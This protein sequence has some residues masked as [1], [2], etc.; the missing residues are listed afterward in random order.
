MEIM[1]QLEPRQKQ[2]WK[3]GLDDHWI[4]TGC[5]D[6]WDAVFIAF[7]EYRD[8]PPSL[9][10]EMIRN[11]TSIDP[12][13]MEKWVLDFHEKFQ[14]KYLERAD[15]DKEQRVF[16]NLLPLRLVST[17]IVPYIQKYIANNNK[18]TKGQLQE[19]IIDK[20]IILADYR[21]KKKGLDKTPDE[22]VHLVYD[23]ITNN[24]FNEIQQTSYELI[25]QAMK[26]IGHHLIIIS[27]EENVL[28]DSKTWGG[29]VGEDNFYQDVIIVLAHP[30]NT[31]DSVGRLSYTKD[32]HQ[33]ISR[34]F[35]YDD[36]IV[37]S[38]R[39]QIK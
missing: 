26:N 16:F 13:P 36:D 4:R 27:P 31:Y 2:E 15:M 28:F 21:Q 12:F 23:Y 29:G 34:L 11:K 24:I 38:L 9:Q 17:E 8:A 19:E 25:Q 7:R 32:G 37:E 3:T 1:E 39:K 10:M 20:C 5:N 22:V 35:H 18:T 14:E 33:K 30:D 6:L